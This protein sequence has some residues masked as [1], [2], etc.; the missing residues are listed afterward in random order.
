MAKASSYHKILRCLLL[1]LIILIFLYFLRRQEGFQGGAAEKD[2]KYVSSRGLLFSCDVYPKDPVSS[3]KIIGDL[4]LSAVEEG[5][6][7]YLQSSAVKAMSKQLLAVQYPFILVTGDCDEDVPNDIFTESEFQEFI[8]SEKI[9]H[10]FSQNSVGKHA[11]LTQIPIG[12]DYHT[13]A[14]SD[15]WG[16]RMNPI[17]Q[18]QEILALKG[19]AK[20][21]YQRQ[22]KAYANFQ[23]SMSG[24]YGQDRMDAKNSIPADCV[25]YEPSRVTQSETF[26]HQIEYAFVISPHGNGLDCH[27]TWEALVLGCIPIVKTSALDSLFSDLPVLIVDSWSQVNREMLSDTLKEYRNRQ[28]NYDKLTLKFW[29]DMIRDYSP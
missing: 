4:D 16:P 23:F 21:F 29:V 18:E 9:L 25:F 17:G 11:K 13:R 8:G 22:P 2:C 3:V 28:F 7:V 12:L 10:W 6:T 14:S 24:K 15:K 26:Q 1:V 5:S 27:R 19:A 20:P